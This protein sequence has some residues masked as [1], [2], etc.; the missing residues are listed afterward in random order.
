MTIGWCSEI[1]ALARILVDVRSAAAPEGIQEID[2]VTHGWYDYR[3]RSPIGRPAQ[4][5]VINGIR[6]FPTAQRLIDGLHPARPLFEV[7]GDIPQ[8][9]ECVLTRRRQVT[10]AGV[11]D[12][13]PYYAA[14][15]REH[16]QWYALD[17]LVWSRFSCRC[18]VMVC[19]EMQKIVKRNSASC[20]QHSGSDTGSSYE[21]APPANLVVLHPW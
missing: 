17:K 4:T 21:Q 14:A 5:I 9:H 16:E 20:D 8:P 19:R 18:V 10:A 12:C 13:V 6:K 7:A 11:P 3:E 1:S 15:P 2:L